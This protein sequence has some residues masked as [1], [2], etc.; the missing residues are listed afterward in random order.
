MTDM[1]A[2]TVAEALADARNRLKIAGADTP[3]LDARVLLRYVTGRDDAWIFANG[4]SE[5]EQATLGGF[6]ECLARR[7]RREPVS[8]IVAMREFW[9]R[10][11]RITPDVLTPRPDTETLVNTVLE[12][13]DDRSAPL[14]M[15][16]LGTGYGDMFPKGSRSMP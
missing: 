13:I 10:N 16:D 14:R 4:E 6:V 7:E 3:A 12:R 11:F 8:Q 2:K 9:S 15:L 5:I 1:H